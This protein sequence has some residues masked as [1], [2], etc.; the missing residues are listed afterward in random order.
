VSLD[1]SDYFEGGYFKGDMGASLPA[2]CL[3]AAGV[4]FWSGVASEVAGGSVSALTL[5]A[6]VRG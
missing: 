6:T 3:S 4:G 5:P 1:R 2:G